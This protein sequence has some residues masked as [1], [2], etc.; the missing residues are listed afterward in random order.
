MGTIN[1]YDYN[2]RNKM[3]SQTIFELIKNES[4]MQL[5]IAIILFGIPIFL[6]IYRE[7]FE[8]QQN[9]RKYHLETLD[10][11]TNDISDEIYSNTYLQEKK[12]IFFSYVVGKE[13]FSLKK[14]NLFLNLLYKEILTKQDIQKY[15]HYFKLHNEKFFIEISFFDYVER[16]YYWL[17]ALLIFLVTIMTIIQLESF[18]SRD[19][20]ITIVLLF[21][22][23]ILIV[24]GTKI[25]KLNIIIKKIK[26]AGF[27]HGKN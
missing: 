3:K 13:I 21:M 4:W 23:M 15:S 2:R 18:T 11:L 5:L 10:K 9:K 27:Y 19:F 7:L 6:K 17:G 12:S 8:L 24:F 20:F 25:N 1:L 14:R 26:E 22:S 16:A